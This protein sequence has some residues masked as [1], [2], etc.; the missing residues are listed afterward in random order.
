MTTASHDD[1]RLMR[2][3]AEAE[4][5]RALV[6]PEARAAARGAFAWRTIDED[7]MELA[8][9]SARGEEVLV[10]DVALDVHVV[11]FRSEGLTLEVERDGDQLSGQ[12]VRADP[13]G[14]DDPCRITLVTRSGDQGSTTADESGFFSLPLAGES[15][16]R[17]RV[18]AGGRTESTG[19]LPL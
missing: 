15:P 11:G 12:V 3:L 9:D 6:T 16:W 1:D 7:L 10:R 19:W 5:A 18:E 8:F 2:L 13:T 14:P 4:A 17:L